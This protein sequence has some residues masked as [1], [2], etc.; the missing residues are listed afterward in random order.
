VVPFVARR[1]RGARKWGERKIARSFSAGA[2]FFDLTDRLGLEL[3]MYHANYGAWL[4]RDLT[5]QE[6]K[7]VVD[8]AVFASHAAPTQEKRAAIVNKVGTVKSLKEGYLFLKA[9]EVYLIVKECN[10]AS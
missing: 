1:T 7:E 3:A 2:Q 5:A 4:M 10:E 9:I 6:K 8:A